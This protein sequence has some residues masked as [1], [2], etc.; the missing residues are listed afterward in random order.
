MLLSILT[1]FI[2]FEVWTGLLFESLITAMVSWALPTFGADTAAAVS[3]STTL[4][5]RGCLFA[6][7]DFVEFVDTATGFDAVEL[8]GVS[9]GSSIARS[10]LAPHCKAIPAAKESST[11]FASSTAKRFLTFRIAIARS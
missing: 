10:C 3:S 6:G 2:A 9:L 5:F 11:R 8:G 7:G 1:K 4:L